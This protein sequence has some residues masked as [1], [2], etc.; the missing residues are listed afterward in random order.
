MLRPDGSDALWGAKAIARFIG[1]SVDYV[2]GLAADPSAPVYKPSGRYYSTKAELRQWLRSKPVA[3][4]R[5][6][7]SHPDFS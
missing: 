1:A 6:S 5:S 3:K 7:Q 2:Y 4:P